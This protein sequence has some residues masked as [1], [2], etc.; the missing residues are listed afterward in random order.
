[1]KKVIRIIAVAMC[2]AL[3]GVM[4]CSCQYLDDMKK[5]HAVYTDDSK[6]A[7]EFKDHIY[8][9]FSMPENIIP[10]T[11]SEAYG[12]FTYVTTKDVPVLLSE[13]YGDSFSFDTRE[14][15]PLI[16]T[17]YNE[18]NNSV[19][20]YSN[21]GTAQT[22]Q[23]QCYVRE[24]RY[25][26]LSE[27]MKNATLDHYYYL[28]DNYDSYVGNN[29]DYL[30]YGSISSVDY[31]LVSE[32]LTNA[33][34]DTIKSGKKVNYKKLKDEGWNSFTLNYCDK[35]R[36][37][38]DVSKTLIILYNRESLKYYLVPKFPAMSYSHGAKE[39]FEVSEKYHKALDQLF[40]EEYDSVFTEDNLYQY[41]EPDETDAYAYGEGDSGEIA[42]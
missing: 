25:D 19:L 28:H 2:V 35:N 23:V 36:L 33:I 40:K 20:N 17:C 12:E 16:L 32:E 5:N 14:K 41:F 31:R 8:K 13:M 11:D 26:E 6:E 1:M 24:D 37:V 38:T 9:G 3:L 10:I 39:I 34:N 7:I 22:Y 21:L 15:T 42:I 18:V 27:E 29:S 4:L 30:D